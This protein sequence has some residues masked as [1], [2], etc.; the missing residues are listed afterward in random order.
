MED[1]VTTGKFENWN[2][3]L[4]NLKNYGFKQRINIYEPMFLELKDV[5]YV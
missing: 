3:D 1:E 2:P 4:E 5:K